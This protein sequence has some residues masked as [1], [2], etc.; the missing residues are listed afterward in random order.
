M[1]HAYWV[2][3]KVRFTVTSYGKNSDELLAQLSTELHAQ[4]W[5]QS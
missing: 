3:Q 1:Q 4:P 2:G 5:G